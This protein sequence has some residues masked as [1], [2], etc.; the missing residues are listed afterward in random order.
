MAKWAGHMRRGLQLRSE[1]D[2]L[3]ALSLIPALAEKKLSQIK[4]LRGLADLYAEDG[5]IE[6]AALL[7]ERI[8]A[9]AAA[10]TKVFW[11]DYARLLFRLAEQQ[12]REKH[13]AKASS[14]LE[15]V[16]RI[17]AKAP[18]HA[19]MAALCRDGYLQISALF[20]LAGAWAASELYFERALEIAP[21]PKQPDALQVI[22]ELCWRAYWRRDLDRLDHWIERAEAQSPHALHARHGALLSRIA[23]LMGAIGA[24]AAGDHLPA[25]CDH[26]FEW[27][28]ALL[29]DAAP[30]GSIEQ[31]DL[32]V[33]WASCSKDAFKAEL[34]MT[35]AMNM[36]ALLLGEN[37]PK[38][39]EL[40]MA[41]GLD[42]EGA[43]QSGFGKHDPQAVP[44]PKVRPFQAARKADA[45]E[46][47]SMG[48][49]AIKL[50]HPDQ[51][52]SDEEFELRNSMLV[53]VNA[54]VRDKDGIKLAQLTARFRVELKNRDWLRES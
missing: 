8:E 34:R 20:E 43:F 15:K 27:G 54:A 53:E 4:T 45:A 5:R 24:A 46:L 41:L 10:P 23:A 17:A 6:D 30:Q 38:T 32:L 7:F 51:A 49:L 31:A 11:C 37:H 26:Y 28:L 35:D 3:A 50:V 14:S 1:R 44:E 40:R 42:G 47:K 25:A 33:A 39:L 29:S 52:A 48:R 16:K 36:R 12:L 2:Y 22:G 21:E 19:E 18:G 9:E 13:V